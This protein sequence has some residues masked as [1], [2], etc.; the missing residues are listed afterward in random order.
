MSFEAMFSPFC[1]MVLRAD[2]SKCANGEFDLAVPVLN[3]NKL[4]KMCDA[5]MHHL[6]KEKIC[7]VLNGPF[8]IVGD[9][10]GHL[11]DLLR[12]LH[13]HGL[14]PSSRYLFLGD[15]VDR[16][17]F[18]L[19]TATL[20]FLM[21]VLWPTDVFI[22]RGNHEFEALCSRCGFLSQILQVY[23][24]HHVFQVFL[25]VF[26]ELPIAAIINSA[27]LCV[28]G[29]LDPE[30]S[31]IQ[32]ISTIT[33]PFATSSSGIS[34]SLVWSDPDL[35]HPG[36]AK[37]HR[38][39]GFLFGA[40]VFKDFMDRNKLSKLIRGHQCVQ[41][42]VQILFDDRL[43]TVFSASNY[44]GTS[45]N[46][47][48]VLTVDANLEIQIATYDPIPAIKRKTI[49]HAPLVR[50]GFPL[51][52]IKPPRK[53]GSQVSPVRHGGIRADSH[54]GGRIARQSSLPFEV[55]KTEDDR[56]RPP[57]PR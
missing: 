1:S 15:I 52:A 4:V 37:S 50:S 23:S 30:L 47:S 13:V 29:G 28:H 26:E 33:R 14:P 34:E 11:I 8:V 9:L 56:I 24:H 44:C 53:V 31:S 22:I 20:I 51:F 16:G 18:S 38:G 10:H 17:E 55:L 6:K 43:Y 40:D 54:V 32:Q 57:K 7:L 41:E 39:S 19:E 12:I 35:D 49:Q 46:R 2:P 48:G 45:D 36:F 27:I 25:R 5:V 42:G 21:K 3:P